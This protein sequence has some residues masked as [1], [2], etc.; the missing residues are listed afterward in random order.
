[1]QK[2]YPDLYQLIRNDREANRYYACLPD[3]V[4]DSIGRR[5]ESVNSF[6]SLRDYAENL[7]RADD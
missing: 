6:E 7:T 4:K 1:M 2:K 5:A 3:S